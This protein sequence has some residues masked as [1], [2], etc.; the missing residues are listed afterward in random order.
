[1]DQASLGVAIALLHGD[2]AHVGDDEGA[3]HRRVVTEDAINAAARRGARAQQHSGGCGRPDGGVLDEQPALVRRASAADRRLVASIRGA[4]AHQE[5]GV[6]GAPIA[7]DVHV[8]DVARP[9]AR[10]EVRDPRA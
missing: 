10:L 5:R 4:P 1:M 8:R 7:A 9:D 6:G 2:G 3:G